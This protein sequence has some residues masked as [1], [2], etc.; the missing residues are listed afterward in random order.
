M[1]LK[2]YA[3]KDE[4]GALFLPEWYDTAEAFLTRFSPQEIS[5]MEFAQA[6]DVWPGIKI[7]LDDCYSYVN[8]SIIEW[9][10]ITPEVLHKH[11]KDRKDVLPLFVIDDNEDRIRDVIYQRGLFNDADKYSNNLKETEVEWVQIYT[12][13]LKKEC[14]KYGFPYISI[15]KNEN[16][17]QKILPLIENHFEI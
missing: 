6:H 7:M 3:H 12:E 2:V 17:I 4:T 11:L 5:D 8:G 16:D 10:D 9:V 15:E 1:I 14:Q 13:Q